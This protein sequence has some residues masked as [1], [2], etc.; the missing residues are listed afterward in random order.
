MKKSGLTADQKKLAAAP[1]IDLPL[2][3]KPSA[4]VSITTTAPDPDQVAQEL[5]GDPTRIAGAVRTLIRYRNRLVEAAPLI[6]A[7]KKRAE[8]A[9]R[10][11]EEFNKTRPL[12][13]KK[14]AL[15]IAA[16]LMKKYP[17]LRLPRRTN[18]LAKEVRARLVK[19]GGKQPEVRT[20]R[21]WLAEAIPKK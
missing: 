2:D 4:E 5:R 21:R 9:K 10:T 8:S 6:Q 20:L 11:I 15:S 17:H 18:E 12:N 3:W 13:N 1:K 14:P 19:L 7:A 16:D